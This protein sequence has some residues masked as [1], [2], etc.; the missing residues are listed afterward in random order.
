MDQAVTLE[1]IT[2]RVLAV[3]PISDEVS[4]GSLYGA[5]LDVLIPAAISKLDNEGVRLNA[6]DKEGEYIFTQD[7]FI[8]QDY[9]M[10]LSY[11]VLKDMDY[12]TNFD[13][14]TEQYITRVNT[15]RCNISLKQR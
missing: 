12:D 2:N 10:C 7:S 4:E 1:Y 5:Q 8:T 3:L 15:L 6:K 13:Y 9:I 11:Q 14:L